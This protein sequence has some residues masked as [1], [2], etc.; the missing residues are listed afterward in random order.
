MQLRTVYLKVND[1]Q[2]STAFWQRLLDQKPHRQ[3][4]KW[5]EFMIGTNRLGLLLND[6]GDELKG[7]SAVPVFE[8]EEA[9]LRDFMKRAIEN[10]ASVVM[11]GLK[12]EAMKSVVLSSP[13]G[14][15]FELCMCHA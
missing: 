10:G 14:H 4:T 8:F 2:I 9:R 11:D 1:M 12:I 3:S 13:D 6:F 7:S 15:E 5:T